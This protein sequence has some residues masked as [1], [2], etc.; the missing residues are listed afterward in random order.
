MLLW[1]VVVLVWTPRSAR[2]GP[3]LFFAAL[4]RV[5]LLF[6]PPT[7]S[8][9]LYRYL[10]EGRVWLAGF[11][12][13]ALAPDAAELAGVRDADWAL[14]NHRGVP[15]VYP[16]LA[17]LLFV[18]LSGGGALLWKLAMGLCDLGSVYV[19]FA[20]D[21]R[22]G[23]LWALLPLPVV[24]TAGSGHLEGIGVLLLLVALSQPARVALWA[25]WAGAM[26][27]LLPG[28]ILL[29]LWLTAR[30]PPAA[31]L[32]LV[33]ASLLVSLPILGAGPAMFEGFGTYASSW[34]FN[35]SLYPLLSGFL[36]AGLARTLLIAVGLLITVGVWVRVRDPGRVAVWGLGAFVCLS[37]TVHPWYVLWVLAAGLYLGLRSWALLAAL[38]P[39]AYLVLGTLDPATGRW[40][41]S[42]W[43]RWAIYLPFYA[44]SGLE[45]WRRW[46]RPGPWPVH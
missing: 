8:D 4:L 19:L 29:P 9:D 42:G 22:A 43:V 45:G 31:G 26:I 21:V 15:S 12:P 10:W 28:V 2:L 1:G 32:G 14:V 24:E 16:P 33:V 37:P 40:E 5:I 30:R 41:E 25:A 6:S 27:K 46:S 38:M 39:L 11:N 35:G 7:L 44:A 3:V 34:S 18:G 13:F 20:R 17:Q 36:G 23:W